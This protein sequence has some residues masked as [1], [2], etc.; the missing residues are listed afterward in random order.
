[1][2]Y[3]HYLT[4]FDMEIPKQVF[5]PVGDVFK[6][7]IYIYLWLLNIGVENNSEFFTRNEN[8]LNYI[9]AKVFDKNR[10]SYV[11]MRHPITILHFSSRKL[12]GQLLSLLC[13]AFLG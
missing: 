3:S 6:S 2:K 9:F 11:V 5:E 12:Q 7:H 4:L 8:Y 13:K 10:S 1:M